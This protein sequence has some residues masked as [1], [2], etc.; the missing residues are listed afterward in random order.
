MASSRLL[1][2]QVAEAEIR[3]PQEGHPPLG[4]ESWYEAQSWVSLSVH[5]AGTHVQHGRPQPPSQSLPSLG[6]AAPSLSLSLPRCP[7]SDC[8]GE[9]YIFWVMACVSRTTS[10]SVSRVGNCR[11]QVAA[12]L[13]DPRHPHPN[14]YTTGI[15]GSEFH[16]PQGLAR[17]AVWPWQAQYGMEAEMGHSP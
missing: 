1:L 3:K 15:V 13:H 17:V 7:S 8:V 11:M 14:V 12:G 16:I 10:V 6:I 5:P 9:P 4:V 2:H